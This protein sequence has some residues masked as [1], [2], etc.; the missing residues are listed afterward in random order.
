MRMAVIPARGGSKRIPRKNIRHFCGKPMLYYAID[1][2]KASGLFD[3]IVVSTEDN[4]IA[5]VAR[6]GGA[7]V[8]FMRPAALADDYA[9]TN[10]VICHAI[11]EGTALG[12]HIEQV[13]CIYATVP[14]LTA[15]VI[16]EAHA[17]LNNGIDYVF[18]AAHFDFPVHRGLLQHDNGGVSPAFPEHIGARSQDLPE[19]IHDAGQIYWAAS[20]TWL[21]NKPV[22]SP[23]SRAFILP[24]DKVVDIDTEED[25]QLA[26]Q[27]FSKETPLKTMNKEGH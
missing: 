25:W 10:P 27:I 5:D 24:R 22:F 7:E 9:G 23:N 12:W 6:A 16:Q 26:K 17:L 20:Q 4:E 13:C 11:K 2:A 14:L 18:T 1:A 19:L 21:D 15:Q 3:H 8:P